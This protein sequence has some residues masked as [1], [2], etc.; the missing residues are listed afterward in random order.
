VGE[1]NRISEDDMFGLFKRRTTQDHLRQRPD[2]DIMLEQ[3]HSTPLTIPYPYGKTVV[4][5]M[6]KC[7]N[8]KLEWID[9]S[10]RHVALCCNKCNRII[11]DSEKDRVRESKPLKMVI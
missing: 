8:K 11:Y 5:H 2:P 3:D 6:V 4:T 1:R 10:F 7:G 9:V